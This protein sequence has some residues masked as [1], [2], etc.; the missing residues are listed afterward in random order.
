MVNAVNVSKKLLPC[1]HEVSPQ[2]VHSPCFTTL[3]FCMSLF[4]ASA[5]ENESIWENN[6]TCFTDIACIP[7]VSKM[8]SVWRKMT[9]TQT[10][11]KQIEE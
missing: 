3:A 11:F 10:F 8:T 6:F 4:V 7:L 2:M 5:M 9:E 1:L